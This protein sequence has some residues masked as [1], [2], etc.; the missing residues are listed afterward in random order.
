M[1]TA[2]SHIHTGSLSLSRIGVGVVA[3]LVGGLVFGALMA[4]MDM[5][6]MVA[7]LVNSESVAVGW[8][9]HLAISAAFGAGFAVLF[10]ALADRLGPALLL[11]VGYGIF[12]WVLGA[13]VLMPARLGM[14]LF[15]FGATAWQSLI[16]HLMYG[17]VL[18]AV[19]ALVVR[20]ISH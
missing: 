14:D 16:G 13:L 2:H 8:V 4:A 17:V 19:Y 7:M 10:G 15:S 9:V 3:G 20:R 11:G 1:S 6:G 18:G 12:W 5:L